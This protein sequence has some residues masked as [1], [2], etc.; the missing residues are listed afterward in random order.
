MIKESLTA[1]FESPMDLGDLFKDM[2]KLSAR[3]VPI[4]SGRIK[5]KSADIIVDPTLQDP[6]D[7]LK[8]YVDWS[9]TGNNRKILV[10]MI[11]MENADLDLESLSDEF[12]DKLGQDLRIEPSREIDVEGVHPTKMA[13]AIVDFYIGTLSNESLK[14]LV[15]ATPQLQ[16]Y[17]GVSD[18]ADILPVGKEPSPGTRRQLPTWRSVLSK[19]YGK[20]VRSYPDDY[21]G[22]DLGK[23]IKRAVRILINNINSNYRIDIIPLMR[24]KYESVTDKVRKLYDTTMSLRGKSVEHMGSYNPLILSESVGTARWKFWLKSFID[25]YRD[26]RTDMA[27]AM[28]SQQ[29]DIP[30]LCVFLKY[31]DDLS[32]DKDVIDYLATKSNLSDRIREYAKKLN[33]TLPEEHGNGGEKDRI[34]DAKYAKY[35]RADL[36][37]TLK[38]FYG[39]S[40]E[41]PEVA[42]LFARIGIQNESDINDMDELDAR[43]LVASCI[44]IIQNRG[45]KRSYRDYRVAREY[46]QHIISA[47]ESIKLTPSGDLNTIIARAMSEIDQEL[48]KI[49]RKAHTNMDY[50]DFKLDIAKPIIERY[51]REKLD[52]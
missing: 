4:G 51:Y 21:G 43:A 46:D 27:E 14:K 7:R 49:Y 33:V 13:R 28:A 34:I 1:L 52:P 45:L 29:T 18:S 10:H 15:E 31:V 36:I 22:G 8:K 2:P 42:T 39:Y 40:K 11:Q 26:G 5:S 50:E 12:I 20:W 47:L 19:L 9:V 6:Y 44:Q 17:P 32:E 35:T 48:R 16:T 25:N 3:P 24:G 38:L 37:R 30:R 23:S 41:H